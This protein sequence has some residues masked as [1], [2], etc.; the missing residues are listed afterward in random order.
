MDL[1][2]QAQA[3]DVGEGTGWLNHGSEDPIGP[4]H[5]IG[6]A[7]STGHV[8]TVDSVPTG[9]MCWSATTS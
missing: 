6:S 1:V 4:S 9:W 7:D 3:V 8:R 2:V 5:L